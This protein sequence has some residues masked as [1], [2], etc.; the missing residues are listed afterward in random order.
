VAEAIE[1]VRPFAVDVASG[2][3]AS[4][5][6]KDPEKLRAFADAVRSTVPVV[7]R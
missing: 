2:T 5:G 6:T 1:A 3:E 4:P 7:S